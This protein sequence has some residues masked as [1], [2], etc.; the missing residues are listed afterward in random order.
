[1]A[2][3][4]VAVY[5]SLDTSKNFLSLEGII[6][7]S[8][9][10]FDLFSVWSLACFMEVLVLVLTFAPHSGTGF[11]IY[12]FEKLLGGVY[13]SAYYSDTIITCTVN[14]CIKTRYIHNQMWV[15]LAGRL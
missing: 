10:S 2:S 14:V 12:P 13:Y 11:D 9:P 1:V 5:C 3:L 8:L 6:N 4:L 7:E 15:G